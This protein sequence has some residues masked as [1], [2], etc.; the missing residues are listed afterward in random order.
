MPAVFQ[1]VSAAAGVDEGATPFNLANSLNLG[2]PQEGGSNT[3]RIP[4][5]DVINYFNRP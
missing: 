3:E 1:E 2:A 4:F 5:H